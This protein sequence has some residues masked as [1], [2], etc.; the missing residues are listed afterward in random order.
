MRDVDIDPDGSKAYVVS[1]GHFYYPACDTVNAFSMTPG[2]NVQPLWSAK[3]GDTMEAVAADKDAVY[4]SGHFRYLET[5]TRTEPRFQIAA[6]DPDTGEGLNWVPNAGGFR[7]VLT[8]ELEPAG[9]FSG[10]DGDAY[11]V[12]NHGRNAFWPTPAPGIEVRKAP[13]RPWVLGAVRLGHL[14]GPGAQHLHRPR[15]HRDRR[16]TTRGWATSTARAPARC[17]RP[18]Q[19][20][21]CTAAPPRRRRSAG[22]RPTD[23]TGT[24]TATADAGGAGVTDT[25]TST[26][27]II[28]TRR[29]V[30]ASGPWSAPAR[31]TSPG[32]TVRFNVTMMNLDPSGPRRSPP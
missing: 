23:V 18:S 24:V 1:A 26:V 15:G 29:V 30:P 6:L 28:A 17:R 5:E 27:N 13:S 32:A 8:L 31:S 19:P 2:A 14:Q 4:I 22:P 12:V 16:S 9:L 3:I 10:S 25:D 11:G 20:G 7:G 21:R